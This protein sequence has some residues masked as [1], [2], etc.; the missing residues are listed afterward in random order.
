[1]NRR[2]V[3]VL[4][5]V[6]ATLACGVLIAAQVQLPS[7]PGGQFGRSI[8]GAFEGWYNNKDGSHAFLVGYYNRNLGQAEDIPIGPNNRI[9]P[10]GP[11]YGQPT[12][13]LPGRQVGV[14]T[15]T[16]PKDFTSQQRLTWTITV[17]GMTNAIPFRLHTDYNVSPFVDAAVGNTPP[18]LKLAEAGQTVQG[19]IAQLANAESRT[20][21]VNTPM[22]LPLWATD[23]AKYTSGHERAHAQSAAARHRHV[24]QVP[25]T[26]RREVPASQRPA[27]VRHDQGRPGRRSVRRQGNSD[28]H[29]QRARRLRARGRR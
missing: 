26:R 27:E 28:R 19:P 6:A 22:E 10:G 25:W 11:D 24:V 1:M 7:E 20:A 13:F 15:V 12:H 17:N 23:D 8:T 18:V 29:L 16:V 4:S 3:T 2:I 14:F 21:T 5:V 9:E